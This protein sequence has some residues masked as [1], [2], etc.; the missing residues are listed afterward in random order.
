MV[1][2]ERVVAKHQVFEDMTGGPA[3]DLLA[4]EERVLELL[5]AANCPVPRVLGTDPDTRFIF[6]EHRGRLTFDDLCQTIPS[7]S[8]ELGR[9]IIAGFCE[10]ESVFAARQKELVPV[11]SPAGTRRQLALRDERSLQGAEE[12]VGRFARGAGVSGEEIRHLTELLRA[13]TA[14]LGS[15]LPTLGCMDYNARNVVVDE[16]TQQSC[17]IEFAKIGWDWPER[18]LVQYGTSLGAGR[19]EGEFVGL[20]KCPVVDYYAGKDSDD[21]CGR[22]LALDGHHLHFNLNAF[23][24][25]ATALDDPDK[26]AN[27]ALLGVWRPPRRRLRQLVEAVARPLSDDPMCTEFRRSIAA[28]AG[29]EEEE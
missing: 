13:I 8:A 15:R 9:S 27:R 4:V 16:S 14:R 18:R 23:A 19:D 25:L 11:T 22:A 6:F 2:G 24:M 3:D 29:L 10:I 26:P 7:G 20:I 17:F 5:A 28:L 21:Y 12:G 1:G